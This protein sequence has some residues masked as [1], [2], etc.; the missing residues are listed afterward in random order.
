MPW[1]NWSHALQLLRVCATTTEAWASW[2]LCSATREATAMRTL[3]TLEAVLCNK[4]SHRNENPEHPEEAHSPHL[5]QL[6][7]ACTQQQRHNAAKISKQNFKSWQSDSLF[8]W[9]DWAHA[10]IMSRRYST[11]MGIRISILSCLSIEVTW[12]SGRTEIQHWCSVTL[13]TWVMVQPW[14]PCDRRS[15]VLRL[16]TEHSI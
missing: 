3:S 4:R 9:E 14:L 15:S 11:G 13:W 5:P 12:A 8:S 2:K 10:E 1:N 7:N 16:D 6:E